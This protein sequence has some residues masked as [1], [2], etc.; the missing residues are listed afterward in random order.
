MV[1]GILLQRVNSSYLPYARQH[2][3][4]YIIYRTLRPIYK[5]IY[6]KTVKAPKL[7]HKRG[8]TKCKRNLK[9]TAVTRTNVIFLFPSGDCL[10]LSIGH[11]LFHAGGGGG[12]G[13]KPSRVG[14][15]GP[16]HP[17]LKQ[18]GHHCDNYY[19]VRY[20]NNCFSKPVL[21]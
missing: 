7:K 1:L 9:T 3:H 2:K 10:S 6:K 18:N 14:Q 13:V 21:K 8:F 4:K 20:L 11:S 5:Y 16:T 17:P 12:G 19:D 15:D